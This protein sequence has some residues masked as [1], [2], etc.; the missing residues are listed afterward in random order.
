MLLMVVKPKVAFLLSIEK[1]K[2]IYNFIFLSLSF[3][4]C[5]LS[6]LRLISCIFCSYLILI[7]SSDSRPPEESPLKQ[8]AMKII[9][10]ITK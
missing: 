1:D 5:N 2:T 10:T 3:S 6:V 8:L 4:F 7:C 9:K